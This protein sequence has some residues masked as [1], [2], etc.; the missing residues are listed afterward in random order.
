MIVEYNNIPGLV[1]KD[2]IPFINNWAGFTKKFNPFVRDI[3]PMKNTGDAYKTF[4]TTSKAPWPFDDRY[5]FSVCYP[6]IDFAEDEHM[7]I[8]SDQ[9]LEPVMDAN[10]TENEK[11]NFVFSRMTFGT[12]W[13]KPVRD[14][15]G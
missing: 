5:V 12:W 3:V 10:I 8:V 13:F 15:A 4:K 2:F 1:P 6:F 14:A 11:K 7:L 9:G